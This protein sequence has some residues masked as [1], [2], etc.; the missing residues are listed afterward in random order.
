M[1]NN[2]S[3][4]FACKGS[5]LPVQLLIYPSTSHH[6]PAGSD[7]SNLR[8]GFTL[9]SCSAPVCCSAWFTGGIWHY[10]KSWHQKKKKKNLNVTHTVTEHSNLSSGFSPSSADIHLFPITSSVIVIDILFLTAQYFTLYTEVSFEDAGS[11]F[12]SHFIAYG[13]LNPSNDEDIFPHCHC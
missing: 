1:N 13:M 5:F 7:L 4:Y 2:W 8:G 10:Y 12:V 3:G 9:I 11:T 6:P